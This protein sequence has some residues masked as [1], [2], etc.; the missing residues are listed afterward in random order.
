LEV[1]GHRGTVE[2]ITL[3]HTVINTFENR[4]VI[5]P[6]ALISDEVLI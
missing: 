4:R 3:R 2:D 5:I 1:A 6:N